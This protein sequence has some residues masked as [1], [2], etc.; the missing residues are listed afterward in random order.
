VE[1][2]L[3]RII[4]CVLLLAAT[5]V[6]LGQDESRIQYL[7]NE[8]VM[9][10]HAGTSI[11]FDPLFNNSYGQYQLVPAAMREAIMTGAPPYDGIDAVFISHYHDD[12]FSA[13]DVLQLLK[14]QTGI[15]LYAP[16]Q[17]VVAMREV[18]GD[19]DEDVFKRVTGL[20][21]EYG[22]APVEISTK[23]L[24]IDAVVIPHSG[25]PTA[26]TDV[27]NIV[28]RVT[29]DDSSTVMHMGDADPR[30]VHFAAD[31]EYWEE[32]RVD[33]A[34]PP[35]WFF[36]TS[37]GR[38]ILEERINIRHS[39]GIHVPDRYA[40]PDNVPAELARYEIFTRPGEGRRFKR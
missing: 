7:A 1:L 24:T 21:L 36:A 4:S 26:R 32:E 5:S 29:L 9:V 23:Q 16:T 19:S 25:W 38:E 12:H 18:A 8:G 28:F 13:I 2:V 33:L 34:L 11:L 30:I 14:A 39:I 40:D 22:D 31:E 3:I 35:Y 20:D 10:S 27:R 6:V 37:D 15:H 17:A